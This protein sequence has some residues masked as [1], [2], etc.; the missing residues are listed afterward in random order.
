MFDTDLPAFAVQGETGIDLFQ[1]VDDPDARRGRFRCLATLAPGGV[2]TDHHPEDRRDPAPLRALAEALAAEPLAKPFSLGDSRSFPRAAAAGDP[3]R[4]FLYLDFFR[5][6]QVADL[7]AARLESQLMHDPASLPQ[8]GGALTGAVA[9]L[10][11]FNRTGRGIA[12]AQA[13]L[14]VLAPRI[15]AGGAPGSTG[16]A[17][18]ML[19]DQ[20][21]RGGAA[22]LALRCFE[23]ALAT[24]DNAF[25]RRRAIEAAR[26]AGDSAAAARHRSL[27]AARWK[28]PAD[29][30]AGQDAGGGA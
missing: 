10:F 3:I 5:A 7:A 21:L 24:G 9:P 26:A 30:A 8:D 16:Y 17:L 23:T 28:L 4:L 2:L 27:Y 19:G 14:P 15:A 22:A 12:L 6:W 1:R 11:D 25:R 13:A 29:L 20:C 18:R